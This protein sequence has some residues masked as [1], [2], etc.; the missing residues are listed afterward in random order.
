MD[1]VGAAAG[2]SARTVSN[3]LSGKVPVRPATKEAVLQAVE[4]LGYQMNVTAR[5]LRTGRT[6]VITLAIPD[7]G[8]DYFSQLARAV[9]VE[10][11]RFGWAVTIQQT[12]SRRE[13]ELAI[14]SGAE[15]QFSDGLIIQPS[16]LTEDDRDALVTAQPM[17]LLGDRVLHRPVDHVGV[18]NVEGARAATEHL[19][20]L[21]R[22]RI[23]V[24]GP[25][26][27][28][29]SRD[30]ALLRLTG[31]RQALQ[32][33]GVPW[34]EE[35]IS[36][37]SVWERSGGAAAVTGLLERGVVFDGLFCVNDTLAFGALHVLARRGV[38]VPRQVAVVGFDDV[39]AAAYSNPPLTTVDSGLP[40]LARAAVTMLARRLA[41]GADL[42]ATDVVVGHRLVRRASA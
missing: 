30:A 6:G 36:P 3:V 19:L 38:E 8:H 26:A 21:G 28:E 16:A 14:I 24:V 11:D 1:D 41:G 13:R 10:A 39:P 42:E 15:R 31:Y 9:M 35:L 12:G 18:A 4:D 40:D 22:R 27:G 25:H 23:A 17:V 34:R 33:A 29:T 2:V 20:S 37:A 7:L 32:S 5:S